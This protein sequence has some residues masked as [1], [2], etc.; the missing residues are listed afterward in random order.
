MG[1][2]M[3]KNLKA[4]I[5]LG[6]RDVPRSVFISKILKNFKDNVKDSTITS[7]VYD[8][9]G[10]SRCQPRAGPTDPFVQPAEGDSTKWIA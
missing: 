3:R 8:Q 7:D 9:Q 5:D 10:I 4:A 2:Y 1:I 6:R